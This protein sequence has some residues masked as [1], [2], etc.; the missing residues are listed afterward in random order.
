MFA[1]MKSRSERDEDGRESPRRLEMD[2]RHDSPL[3]ERSSRGAL[4][5]AAAA[6]VFD[7]GL[8]PGRPLPD[9]VI[10]TPR[11]NNISRE[12]PTYR[13]GVRLVCLSRGVHHEDCRTA[14]SG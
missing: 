1:A 6:P 3:P 5:S 14:P 8:T 12:I 9:R 2:H 4:S 10:Y 7:R 13:A 11:R